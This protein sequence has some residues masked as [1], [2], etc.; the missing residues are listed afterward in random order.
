MGKTGE[1]RGQNTTYALETNNKKPTSSSCYY[2]PK[3]PFIKQKRLVF[4]FVALFLH[5]DAADAAIAVW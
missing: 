1:S 5:D 2:N 3:T 4:V